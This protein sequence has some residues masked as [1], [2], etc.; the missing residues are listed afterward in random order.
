VLGL[1]PWLMSRT[2]LTPDEARR[3]LY[4]DFEGRKGAP[5]V[6]L[7]CTRRSRLR[8]S[9]TVWQ[10]VTE[11]RL[12]PL[13]EADRIETLTLHEAV[14]RILVRAEKRDRLIV[15]WSEHELDVVRVFCPDLLAR[16]EARFRNSRDLAERW[17]NKCH[18]GVKP[19]S[20][21]L[22]DYLWLTG[23]EVPE[24]ARP[25]RVGETVRLLLR[26]LGRGGR[27]SDITDKQL[28]R[29]D[30]LREHNRHDCTGM[31]SVTIQAA[32]EIDAKDHHARRQLESTVTRVPRAHSDLRIA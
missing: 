9:D 2:R 5:P 23:Y 8:T 10:V 17:R 28:A 16:F 24:R 11:E 15:A 20:G 1:D 12:R 21:S 7:G 32:E 25:G 31:R 27:V 26:S 18:A 30:D 29:W 13:G 14:E 4:I 3:A 19:A 6:L 22:A